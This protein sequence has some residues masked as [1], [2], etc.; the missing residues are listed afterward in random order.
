M[1]TDELVKIIAIFC[2]L[3]INLI[4]NLIANRDILLIKGNKFNYCLIWIFSAIFFIL[5]SYFSRV[6][7]ALNLLFY[8]AIG[9]SV[10]QV[11][12]YL[13][14]INNLKVK[15]KTSEVLRSKLGN[16]LY[17]KD[18]PEFVRMKLIELVKCDEIKRRALER[19]KGYIDMG[20][21]NQSK[22]EEYIAAIKM[23]TGCYYFSTN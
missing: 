5:V 2:G 21:F 6:A 3:I 14:I 8:A 12:L 10:P 18:I 16:Y 19:S 23:A 13:M 17:V 11:G 20:I 22:A 4:F 1:P 15:V 9:L 7:E